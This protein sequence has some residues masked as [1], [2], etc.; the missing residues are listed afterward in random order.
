MITKLVQM[1]E[2]LLAPLKMTLHADWD[3]LYALHNALKWFPIKTNCTPCVH[4]VIRIKP[5]KDSTFT[6][7][8]IQCGCR[9]V[10]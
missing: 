4:I 7:E 3:V 2:Y 1:D 10:S 5:N 8:T 9:H 6:P